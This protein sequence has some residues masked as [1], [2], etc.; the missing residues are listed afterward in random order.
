MSH[1]HDYHTICEFVLCYLQHNTPVASGARLFHQL[2]ILPKTEPP[3]DPVA[4]L[5][6]FWAA[7]LAEHESDTTELRECLNDDLPCQEYLVT[8]GCYLLP[9]LVH[10]GIPRPWKELAAN[11]YDS[12]DFEPG[13]CPF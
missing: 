4:D 12:V 6:R 13:L 8:L 3:A 2:Y 1:R 5:N 7:Q 9:N 11:W 10:L